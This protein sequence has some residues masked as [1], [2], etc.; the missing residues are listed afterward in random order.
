[1]GQ[2]S[3]SLYEM[4]V[5][6]IEGLYR[7]EDELLKEEG[8]SGMDMAFGKKGLGSL[9]LENYG[10]DDVMLHLSEHVMTPLVHTKWD[11][12]EEYLAWGNMTLEAVMWT[13][14]KSHFPV[15]S[16]RVQREVYEARKDIFLSLFRLTMDMHEV[17]SYNEL[18]IGV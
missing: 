2:G 9:V 12:K 10:E 7:A 13:V 18:D 8:E 6:D 16:F 4:I 1:M 17:T 3:M 11:T 5:R 14:W 15:I